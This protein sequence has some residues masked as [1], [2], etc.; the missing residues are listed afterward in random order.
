MEPAVPSSNRL[1]HSGQVTYKYNGVIKMTINDDICILFFKILSSCQAYYLPKKISYLPISL[2]HSSWFF[3]CPI[4]PNFFIISYLPFLR[5]TFYLY[6]FFCPHTIK[7]VPFITVYYAEIG[8]LTGYLF[9]TILK[10]SGELLQVFRSTLH[11][12]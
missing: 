12:F 11:T 7:P 10:H 1:L 2:R 8:A 9:Y 6:Y 4:L 3:I 5:Y